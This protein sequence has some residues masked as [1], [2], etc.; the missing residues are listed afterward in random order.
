MNPSFEKD[1]RIPQLRVI[2]RFLWPKCRGAP[3]GTWENTAA[4]SVPWRSG[5]EGS[6]M[7]DPLAQ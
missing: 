4:S 5:L 2:D 3:M 1:T 7:D 6:E